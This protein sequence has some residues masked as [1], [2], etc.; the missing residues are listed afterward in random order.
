MDVF[1]FLIAAAAGADVAVETIRY[2]TTGCDGR[3]PVMVIEVRS[4]GKATFEGKAHTAVI[5]RRDFTV[6]AAQYAEYRQRL[7]PNRPVGERLLDAESCPEPAAL[8]YPSIE[9]R[10]TGPG[11]SDRLLLYLGC[12]MVWNWSTKSASPPRFSASPTGCAAIE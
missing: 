11:R 2:E 1:A 12:E 9:V 3:C 5:G 7:E 4:D 8:N 10:W 6:T